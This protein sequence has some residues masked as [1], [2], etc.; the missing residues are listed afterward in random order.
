MTGE[1][2][3]VHSRRI[4]NRAGLDTFITYRPY[5]P[6]KPNNMVLES[7]FKTI[8]KIIFR[9]IDNILKNGNGMVLEMLSPSSGIK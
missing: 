7:K 5:N 8:T 6:N 3:L 4:I 1:S 2:M 9:F